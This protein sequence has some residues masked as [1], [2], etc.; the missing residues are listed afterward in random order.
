MRRRG[1]DARNSPYALISDEE[2]DAGS[3]VVTAATVAIVATAAAPMT[4]APAPW[5]AGSAAEE[6]AGGD[7]LA[8]SVRLLDEGALVRWERGAD[9]AARCS[10]RWYEG[11]TLL[12]AQHTHHDYFLGERYNVSR[13]RYY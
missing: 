10:V 12:S 2:Q 11:D 7:E 9:D 3:T 8:V 6:G 4:E 13:C 1:N 5:E